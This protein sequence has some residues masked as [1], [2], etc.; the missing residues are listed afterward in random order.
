MISRNL[1]TSPA[2]NEEE[3]A[4]PTAPVTESSPC[5]SKLG[6]VPPRQLKCETLKPGSEDRPY[7]S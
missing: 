2:V 1:A 5:A 7:N 3:G 4:A 6:T